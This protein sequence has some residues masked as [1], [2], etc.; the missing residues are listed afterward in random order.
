M[1]LSRSKE[2]L[3]S[4]KDVVPGGVH[5]NFRSPIYF[6]K[7][8]GSRL[9]DID[10]NEYIDCVVNNGA[11]ILGHGDPEVE[12][13][14]KGAVETGLTVALETELSLKVA[15]QLKEMVPSAERVRFA[16]TGTEAVMKA[17]M[18]AREFTGREK[19]VKLEGGYHGWHDDALISVHPNLKLVGP[20][21]S[22]IPVR[23]S[24]G[25]RASVTETTIPI[26]F[27]DIENTERIITKHKDEI[28][29][30]IVEPVM[31]NSG[32]IEPKVEY[33]KTLRDITHKN[34]IV[35]IFDEVI[36]GFRLAPGGAQEYYGITPD[37]TTLAKAIANGYPLAAVAGKQELMDLTHPRTGRVLYGGT[38]NGQQI[39]LAAASACLEKLKSGEVQ[40]RLHKLTELLKGKFNAM[41]KDL[42][43]AA[44]L[45]GLGGQFQVYFT[46]QEIIDYRSA[47][48]ADE[49]AYIAFQGI[50]FN[51]GILIKPSYLF[52]HG[53]TFSHTEEDIDQIIGAMRKGLERV[54]ENEG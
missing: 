20:K 52:H 5:S 7:A 32:C 28:A 33:L 18:I 47:A 11:C 34:G 41:A 35:L 15:R 13:A 22:P 1:K 50:V 42:G 14:V 23:E 9:W 8:K 3:E 45:Q 6:K 24:G 31:F 44:Q 4:Y 39:A 54:A 16:N 43:V 53:I 25:L 12:A 27:N 30:V 46:D 21:S 51:E 10:G 2:L 48:L 49:R 37:L 26:P 29:A 36:T 38:Y 19:I 17:Q 40:E